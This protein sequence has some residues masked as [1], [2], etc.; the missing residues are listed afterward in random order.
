[1]AKSRKVKVPYDPLNFSDMVAYA[2]A[3]PAKLDIATD[4]DTVAAQAKD[5]TE[6]DGYGNP[7]PKSGLKRGAKLPRFLKKP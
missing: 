7:M 6:G 1:M 3:H 2:Q 5:K 4:W